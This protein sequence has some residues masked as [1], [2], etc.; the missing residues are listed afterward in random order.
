ML[1][2][3]NGA[4]RRTQLLREAGQRAGIRLAVVEWRELLAAP[5]RAEEL[6]APGLLGGHA[7]C[8]IDAPGDDPTVDALLIARGARLPGARAVVPRPLAHGE[9][10]LRDLCF[11]GFADALRSLAARLR[12]PRLRLLNEVEDIL[13]MC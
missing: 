3:G 4:S 8:K 11:H 9:L 7:W 13:L 1:L 2:V 10:G 12:A 5:E 6:L